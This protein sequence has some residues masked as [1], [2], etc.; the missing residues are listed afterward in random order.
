MK[1]I[2]LILAIVACTAHLGA[3]PGPPVD[4]GQQQLRSPQAVPAPGSPTAVPPAASQPGTAAPTGA[5]RMDAAQVNDLLRKMY[6]AAYRVNDLLSLLLPDKW[7]LN[8][9][10]RKSL[11]ATLEL[12]RADLKTLEESRS[13]FSGQ[14]QNVALG[15]KLDAALGPALRNVDAITRLV[16]QYESTSQ[17]SQYTQAHDQLV[18][19]ERALETYLDSLRSSAAKPQ[20]TP[21]QPSTQ[22]AAGPAP[23]TERIAAPSAP[24]PPATRVEEVGS[25]TPEQVKSLLHRIYVAAFRLNDL[26]TQVQPGRWK[27]P[28]PVR[29]HFNLSVARLRSDLKTLEASQTEFA[30]QTDSTYAGYQTYEAIPA[31][32]S[33]LK[34]V[35]RDINLFEDR[36]I[37]GLFD[38]PAQWLDESQQA[39]KTYLDFMLRNRNQ[40]VRT[41]EAN[42]A[43]CQNTLNYAMRS[44]SAPARP[45]EPVRF[46]RPLRSAKIRR[47]EAEEAARRGGQGSGANSSATA[48]QSNSAGGTK[49][50]A[51][52]ANEPGASITGTTAAPATGAKKRKSRHARK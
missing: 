10:E 45:M 6:N 19:L 13:Q 28:E 23:Q 41:Y 16:A 21:G 43:S 4:P 26:L 36:N 15:D 1:T 39:L 27:V 12:L 3:R 11:D 52:L 20:A 32:L 8:E 24:P 37:A 31:V 5:N 9:M 14:I 22:E 33:D 17:A 49:D 46:V 38:Q 35:H 7:K 44:Q 47:K 30:E 29:D 40:V 50:K 18:D 25:M 51:A 34:V 2:L 48:N 42:L